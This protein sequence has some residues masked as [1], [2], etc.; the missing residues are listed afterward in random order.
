M[1]AQERH[2]QFRQESDLTAEQQQWGPTEWATEAGRQDSEI[3]GLVGDWINSEPGSPEYEK[4]FQKLAEAA[5][6]GSFARERRRQ[7][8]QQARGQAA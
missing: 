5:A 7:A 2:G 8:E 3:R 1:A 6:K 4:I